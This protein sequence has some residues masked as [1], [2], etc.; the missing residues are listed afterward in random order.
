MVG[1]TVSQY[2]ILNKLGEGGMGAVYLAEH[3]LLGRRA[4]IKFLK[5]AHASGPE[6]QHLRKR[7]LREAHTLSTFSHPH[8][9]SVYDYGETPEGSPY[10]VMELVDGRTLGDLLR[11]GKL[12]LSQ[13]LSIIADVVEA[14]AE[15]HRHGIIHR[16]IKPSNVAINERGQVKVLDFGIAKYV[17]GSVS[18]EDVSVA[19]PQALTQTRKGFV[20]GTPQYVSPEQA[21]EKS[22]DARSDIFSVGILL[23][24][25]LTGQPAFSGFNEIEI[26][27]KV[28]R[29]TPPPPSRLNPE[30]PPKLDAVA[31]KCLAKSA[32][33]RYQSAE[34][35]LADLRQVSSSL[36]DRKYKGRQ[37]THLLRSRILRWPW[38]AGLPLRS[39]LYVAATFIG[40]LILG[41]ALWHVMSSYRRSYYQPPVEALRWYEKG[42]DALHDGT[43]YK[44]SKL[45][46]EAVKLD[47][48]F[49]LAHA[50]LAEAE[51]ELDYT[52]KAKDELIRADEITSDRF[53][54]RPSDELRLQAIRS[55]VK[56]DFAK[57]AETY[58]A[59]LSASPGPEK[60]SVRVEMG[61][62]FESNEELDRAIE[63]YSEATKLDKQ[64]AAAFLRL[65]VAYGRRLDTDR[66]DA[67]FTEA[68][69][70]F[71]ISSDVEGVTE[72]LYQRGFLYNKLDKLA[73]AQQQFQQALD[74]GQASVSKPQRIKI[75][76]QLSSVLYSAGNPSA[77]QQRAQEA[78]GLAQEE[79]LENVTTN[80]LVDIGY[81]SMWQGKYS[82]AEKYFNQALQIARMNKG[83]RGA[84]RAQLSLGSLYVQEG[85]ANKALG[86]IEPAYAFYQQGNY[87]KEIL[88]ALLL[89][90]RANE[91]RGDYEAAI[92]AYEQEIQVATQIG[93]MSQAGYAH[94]YLGSLLSYQEKFPQAL[95]HF[96]ESY[97]ID[98]NL[99]ALPRIGY[100]LLNRGNVLWQLGRYD[101]ARNALQQATALADQPESHNKQLSAWVLLFEAQMA[102][103]KRNFDDAISKSRQSLSL[104]GEQY[105]DVAAQATGTL[106]LAQ[107]LSGTA[108]A[109]V[110][111]CQHAVDL[112]R[113]VGSP[114]LISGAQLALAE[115]LLQG[116]SA[117]DA[118]KNALASQESFAR[119][120]Q[121]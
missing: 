52:D 70:L 82:E 98:D 99:K 12:P 3:T 57:A 61:H 83:L 39:R 10:I 60:S 17:G 84:A 118:L 37:L 94:V 9:A 76:L 88:Q 27:T 22:L 89:L 40:A 45:F 55:T 25:C 30:V 35:L 86:Y 65:G 79:G 112:A 4:A 21:L 16:D 18:T 72:V 19:Q 93:D 119:S 62:A 50:R 32:I 42:T 103:S 106:G 78:T 71:Q 5:D 28:V 48:N 85:D 77:A 44:A 96:E 120:G 67:A 29:D 68:L 64:N 53:K 117:Q 59:L 63:Q 116:G 101:D 75:I 109:G 41:G 2:R 1:Q 73:Q 13:S 23:Y 102:L 46:E 51:M 31:L 14:L 47:D 108:G 95:A 24:E 105:K 38:P 6:R 20:A 113:G 107:A 90:G 87:R 121:R 91:L 115:A 100:D 114:R 33:D 54:L 43:Y 92:K 69:R 74:M 104:A 15:A 56:R 8:I 97:R 36:G 26:F 81:S 11:K 110:K 111:S 80:G 7:F 66:A 49:A 34:A 58:S